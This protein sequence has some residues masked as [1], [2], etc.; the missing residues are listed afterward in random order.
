MEFVLGL[1]AVLS[2]CIGCIIIAELLC[3]SVGLERQQPS[4]DQLTAEEADAQATY[5]ALSREIER[6]ARDLATQC[7]RRR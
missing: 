2:I 5:E 3:G 1:A 4:V 6:T 7:E